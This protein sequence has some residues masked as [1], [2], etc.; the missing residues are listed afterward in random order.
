LD[1]EVEYE[2]YIYEDA[3]ETIPLAN[4]ITP[5]NSDRNSAKT[6]DTVMKYEIQTN[7]AAAN[8]DTNVT[9]ATLLK[10]GISGAG[11]RVGGSDSR[12]AEIILK[13]GATYCFRAIAKSAGYI[14]FD[15]EWYEHTNVI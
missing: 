8:G 14:D 4:T 7:L 12:E 11:G 5:L 9:G 15:M 3:V 1:T 13:Q 10:S 2:W 6:S